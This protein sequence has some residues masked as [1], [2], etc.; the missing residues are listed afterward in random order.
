MRLTIERSTSET[1]RS[2]RIA[3]QRDFYFLC[4][5]RNEIAPRKRLESESGKK[6]YTRHVKARQGKR[7]LL[8]GLLAIVQ[9]AVEEYLY[10]RLVVVVQYSLYSGV[11][12][13]GNFQ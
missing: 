11:F 8:H 1:S 4:V 9:Q 12:M 6:S 3:S 13:D 7:V 10:I 5:N 2:H